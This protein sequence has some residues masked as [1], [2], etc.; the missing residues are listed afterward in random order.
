MVGKKMEFD[1]LVIGGGTAG[2]VMAS[3]LSENSAYR[4]LLLEAG[5]DTPPGRVPADVRDPFPTSALNQKYFWKG[6]TATATDGG[7]PRYYPQARVMGGGSTINGMLALRGVPSDYMRWT[8]AGTA[9]FSWDSLLPYFRK[10]EN[11]IDRASNGLPR[12]PHAISRIPK[13]RWPAFVHAMEHAAARV[14]LP[15]VPDINETPGDGFFPMPLA[16]GAEARETSA[17]CYLTA[18]VRKRENLFIFANTQVTRL[19]MNG[20]TVEGVDA[21]QDDRPVHFSARN[22]VVS[23][24][25]I[26][27]PAI[28]LRSGI[29]PAAE[30]ASLGIQVVIDRPGVGQNLQ[31]HPYMFY[32]L[33]LPRG[34]RV[35]T[36][37][38]RFAVAGLRASSRVPGCPDG[39][40]FAYAIGRVSG[41]SFGPDFALMG[42]ALYAP[43]SRGFIKLKSTDPVESPDVN[44]RF[45]SDPSDPPR[46]LQAARLTERL[47]RDP[48]V[49]A[50]YHEA[51]L[52]P[53]QLAI[54]QFNRPGFAG[55]VLAMA[56]EAAANSPGPIRRLIFG[57]AFGSVAPLAYKGGGREISDN[58][59]LSSICPMGHPV[60]TCKMG[61]KN[62]RMA[63]VDESFR[64]HGAHNLFVVDASVMP[65]IPSA[66]TNLPTLM[67]AELA[68]DRIPR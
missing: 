55:K 8:D 45:M 16:V 46:M 38:R 52:L 58:E 33:T 1:F 3:R 34:K 49:A 68:A 36:D 57:R 43:N 62:D 7:T 66:N 44:F 11:D 9:T 22:V 29:G 28:L 48:D 47:L 19:C 23:A 5:D 32:A 51:F 56:A 31:N 39:D 61:S 42:S 53:G 41:A 21:I 20:G 12:G 50:Q 13:V 18:D 59:I 37:L 54:A 26:Y 10:V 4:V 65:V 17:G 14:G 27:S 67:L 15:F 25:G 60:G 24:G 40:L 63:V 6:L 2:A 64:V 30:L 35:A